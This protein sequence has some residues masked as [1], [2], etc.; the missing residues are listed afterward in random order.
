V[1]VKSHYRKRLEQLCRYITRPTLSDGRVQFNSAGRVELTPKT[2]WS[3]RTTHL[4]MSQLEFI[5]RLAA[6]VL[7]VMLHIIRFRWV[8]KPRVFRGLSLS[9]T[10]SLDLLEA[11]EVLFTGQPPR[12]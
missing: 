9:A 7:L 3:G 2:P 10:W 11:V 12:T 6:L 8:L 5:L 1:R 4:A